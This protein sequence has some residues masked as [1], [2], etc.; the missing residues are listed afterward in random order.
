MLLPSGRRGRPPCDPPR[1]AP[2][3]EMLRDTRGRA[4]CGTGH[5]Q[6][7]VRCLNYPSGMVPPAVADLAA[8]FHGRLEVTLRSQMP[9]LM[10]RCWSHRLHQR[11]R[12]FAPGLPRM[13]RGVTPPPF[14]RLS[15]EGPHL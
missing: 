4:A 2:C 1:A 12:R 14:P 10:P 6:T 9:E 8:R 7:G 5:L 15:S 3:V 13:P 11:R